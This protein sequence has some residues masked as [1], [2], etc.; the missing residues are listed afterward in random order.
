MHPTSTAPNL[1]SCMSNSETSTLY[2]TNKAWAIALLVAG[3]SVVS[4]LSVIYAAYST[5]SNEVLGQVSDLIRSE[6]TAMARYQ[7]DQFV[8]G[9]SFDAIFVRT[10]F[11]EPDRD[12][13]LALISVLEQIRLKRPS[14]ARATLKRLRAT[15][16][17]LGELDD[18]MERLLVTS[19]EVNASEK[20]LKRTI[21]NKEVIREKYGALQR[22]FA[23]L[24]TLPAADLTDSKSRAP[25]YASG[26]LSGL[27]L[28][29]S[30]PDEIPDAQAL[31]TWLARLG[32][33]VS[34]EGPDV[35]ALFQSEIDSIRS[36]TGALVAKENDLL[37]RENDLNQQVKDGQKALAENWESAAEAVVPLLQKM[38]SPKPLSSI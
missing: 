1:I 6:N 13:A 26:F 23:D 11:G 17:E 21:E 14:A 36:E 22:R 27:P 16:V 2:P 7:I 24:L 20:D 25:V 8:G 37:V 10:V 18:T 38:L 12:N 19:T 34:L 15:R 28:L 32:G 35:P 5:R 31:A 4:S 3:L 9:S 29:R 30:L 33:R